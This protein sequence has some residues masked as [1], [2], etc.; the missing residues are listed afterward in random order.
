MP[1][2][3]D[4]RGR[5]DDEARVALARTD[6]F[7][8]VKTHANAERTVTEV[9]LSSGRGEYSVRR[10]REGHEEGVTLGI[11]LDASMLREHVA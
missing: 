3:A 5:V 9:L 1:R 6:G 4:T 11:D 7:S 2:R 10:S 8:G